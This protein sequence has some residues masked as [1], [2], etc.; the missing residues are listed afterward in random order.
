MILMWHLQQ[1]YATIKQLNC[2]DEVVSF[3]V[4]HIKDFNLDNVVD[5]ND[6]KGFAIC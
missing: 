3:I 4:A 5:V 1:T 2:V 6:S